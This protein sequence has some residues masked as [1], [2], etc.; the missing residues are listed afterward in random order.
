MN[1]QALLFLTPD[2][3]EEDLKPFDT[4][5]AREE[6]GNGS[7]AV[8]GGQSTIIKCWNCRSIVWKDKACGSCG[9]EA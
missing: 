5:P 2:E 4:I 1:Q 9:E 3:P 6:P 8:T 7:Q